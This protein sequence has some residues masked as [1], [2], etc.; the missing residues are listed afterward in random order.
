[1]AA[2]LLPFLYPTMMSRISLVNVITIPP[3]RVRNP[4]ALCDGSWD[5]SD[6]PTCMMPSP[7]SIIPIALIRLKMNV[8]RLFTTVI[9]SSAAKQNL[10]PSTNRITA[11]QYTTNITRQ[12]F[13][14]FSFSFKCFSTL[15][16][17]FLQVFLFNLILRQYQVITVLIL[18][19]KRWNQ[20]Q[21]KV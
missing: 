20:F 8:D 2:F 15:L 18:C 5:L 6:S 14:S 16:P 3:A 11:M 7:S 21:R 1:M 4:F 13:F 12:V 17:S 19:F 10:C 9:E